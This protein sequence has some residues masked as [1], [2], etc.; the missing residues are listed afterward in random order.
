M[1]FYTDGATE[2]I[3]AAKES[4]GERRLLKVCAGSTAKSLVENVTAEHAGKYCREHALGIRFAHLVIN[5]I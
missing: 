2:A 1:F 3:N 4:Y 5:G